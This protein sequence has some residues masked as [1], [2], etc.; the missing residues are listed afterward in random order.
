MRTTAIFRLWL[1]TIILYGLLC[2]TTSTA[3]ASGI[4]DEGTVRQMSGYGDN[5]S[6]GAS[7]MSGWEIL[8]SSASGGGGG[9]WVASPPPTD[10]NGNSNYPRGSVAAYGTRIAGTGTA[11]MFSATFGGAIRPVGP[12]SGSAT[13]TYSVTASWNDFSL[14]MDPSQA[15]VP[16]GSNG[17]FA[18]AW[19]NASG[20]K[21]TVSSPYWKCTP[22]VQTTWQQGLPAPSLPG[23]Y[24][25]MASPHNDD[26]D[27]KTGNLKVVG[28]ASLLPNEGTEFD[29]GDNN[30]DT[31]TFVVSKAASG[32]VT[33]TA[34]PNPNISEANLPV[35]CAGEWTLSGGTGT[36]KLQR[37]VSK[38]TAGTTTLTCTCGTSSKTTK[39]IVV[40]VAS[41]LQY[42]IGSGAYANVTGTIIVVKGTTVDFKAFSSPSGV[43]W[44]S[45][46]PVWGGTSGASGTGDNTTLGESKK[47]VTF[48]TASTSSTDYKTV[49]AECGNTVT[50]NVL[51][52][53]IKLKRVDFGGTGNYVLSKQHDSYENDSFADN[54]SS[55]NGAEWQDDDLNGTA[56]INDPVCYKKG[57]TTTPTF[58][59]MTATFKIKPEDVSVSVSGK[60]KV[61]CDS[62]PFVSE[63]TITIPTSGIVSGLNWDTSESGLTTMLNTYM[64]LDWEFAPNDGSAAY[65]SIGNS[66]TQFFVV[67]D[68]PKPTYS[69]TAKRVNWSLNSSTYGDSITECA[70][71]MKTKVSGSP[72]FN[73]EHP[74]NNLN[75]NTNCNGNIWEYLDQNSNGDCITLAVLACAGLNILG[76][77]ATA[78]V[79]WPTAD[80]HTFNGHQYPAVSSNS[81]R[82]HTGLQFS[83]NGELFLATL[84]YPGNNYEG[85]FYVSDPL[86]KAYT[87]APPGGAFENQ[88]YFYLQVLDFAADEQLWVWDG[89]QT[90]NGVSVTNGVAVPGIGGAFAVPAVP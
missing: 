7:A 2:Q 44:P 75:Y 38:T 23:Q 63:R 9:N 17:G 87:V 83:Y 58:P 21:H 71:K 39:I 12:G 74:E 73:Y 4:V 41:P 10:A 69:L 48:D 49:T 43:T 82:Q 42:K 76:I 67:Y 36:G 31:K 29:D 14:F 46:K 5:Y 52:V 72:G 6:F 18:L 54:G 26:G 20:V 28:V 47:S 90:S 55:I 70:G 84:I 51:V 37:T 88:D 30:N 89:N 27:M 24:T 80:G 65:S 25:V 13:Y 11:Q 19:L 3:L 86:I 50:A 32:E 64:T 16:L 53:E 22:D 61:L 1:M 35:G 85:F 15:V 59:G 79:A 45:G 33:V 68:T 57:T 34:T 78:D 8:S 62:V 40:E 56:E 81:C 66:E 77:E 60:L